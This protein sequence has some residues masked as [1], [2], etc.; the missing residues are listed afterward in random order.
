MAK[1]QFSRSCI[2]CIH[3]GKQDYCSII[4]ET[5]A[6]SRIAEVCDEYFN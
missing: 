6:N 3:L 2:R 1:K 5:I 4:K